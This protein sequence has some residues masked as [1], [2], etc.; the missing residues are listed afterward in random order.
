MGTVNRAVDIAGVNSTGVVD[1]TG[2]VGRTH[3][4]LEC[5]Q[6]ELDCRIGRNHT[7]PEELECKENSMA[8]LFPRHS[9]GRKEDRHQGSPYRTYHS[10]PW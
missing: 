7:E 6:M 5:N 8:S 1:S 4:Q 3:Q 2:V 10:R 9:Q